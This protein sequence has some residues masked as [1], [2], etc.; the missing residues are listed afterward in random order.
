[1]N[2]TRK[3]ADLTIGEII[4]L[5]K[6]L[7][8]KQLCWLLGVFFG[9]LVGAFS[10]GTQ[11]GTNS[12]LQ[13][14]LPPE[15]EMASKR[16]GRAANEVPHGESL[17]GDNSLEEGSTPAPSESE[18]IIVASTEKQGFKFDLRGCSISGRSVVC[19]LI[20]ENLGD[21]RGIFISKA[22]KGITT[23]TYGVK[24][25]RVFDEQSS[26]HIASSIRL[27][28]QTSSGSLDIGPNALLI[29]GTRVPLEVEFEG[30]SSQV[31]SI[32]RLFLNCRDVE[33]ESNFTVSFENIS[34]Q[35]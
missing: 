19:K 9:L 34:L 2:E 27:A 1:M 23:G 22:E 6:G 21:D 13:Q 18:P 28:N 17:A 20:L 5:L 31:K 24:G 11:F 29:S 16:S 7:T 35:T 12:S 30:V 25:S 32:A 33:T 3:T 10:L 4:E 15:E 26:E 8:P 14:G